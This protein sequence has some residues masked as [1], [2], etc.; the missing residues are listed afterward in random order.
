MSVSASMTSGSTLA[1]PPGVAALSTLGPLINI[2]MQG[3]SL[4]IA[5]GINRTSSVGSLSPVPFVALLMNCFIWHCTE[6]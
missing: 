6:S 5:L 4:S 3:S 2:G 1:V